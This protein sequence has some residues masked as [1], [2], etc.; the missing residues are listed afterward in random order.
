MASAVIY[1][2]ERGSKQEMHTRTSEVGS[3]ND[4]KRNAQLS[5]NSREIWGPPQVS[6][7]LET[8]LF[9]KRAQ[10]GL[11]LNAVAGAAAVTQR[12]CLKR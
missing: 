7:E 9:D 5:R 11:P 4:G 8:N 1:H 3:G 6:A 2:A 12:S 10:K